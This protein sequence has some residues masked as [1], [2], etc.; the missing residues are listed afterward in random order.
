MV[1]NVFRATSS[2]GELRCVVPVSNGVISCGV[3]GFIFKHSSG[4]QY[5]CEWRVLQS[6]LEKR[7]TTRDIDEA[8]EYA[9]KQQS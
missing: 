1:D 7:S 3:S 2:L 5:A 9:K 4:K 6:I 8:L